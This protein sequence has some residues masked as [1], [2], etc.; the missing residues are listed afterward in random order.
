[1]R[2]A[3]GRFLQL[4]FVKG[5]LG[6]GG[7][8]ANG[9]DGEMLECAAVLYSASLGW[10]GTCGVVR[11]EWPGPSALV[12]ENLLAG[13][14]QSGVGFNLGLFRCAGPVSR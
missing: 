1:M 6:I 13:L 3:F 10:V 14:G 2:N 8:L 9:V 7:E 12:G 5:A 11:V 4:G